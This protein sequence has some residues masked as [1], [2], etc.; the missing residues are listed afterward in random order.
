MKIRLDLLDAFEVELLFYIISKYKWY[1]CLIIYLG[2]DF[3]LEPWT[4]V[5]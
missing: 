5:I 3:R 2:F 1:S 4:F